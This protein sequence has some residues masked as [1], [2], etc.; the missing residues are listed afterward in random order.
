[1]IILEEC[2]Y[3]G[4]SRGLVLLLSEKMIAENAADNQAVSCSLTLWL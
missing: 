3:T 4:D 2:R 1:M